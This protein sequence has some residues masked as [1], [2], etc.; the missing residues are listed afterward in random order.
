MR[1]HLAS[2]V[3][4][5]QRHGDQ[6][7][8]VSRHGLR[9]EITSYKTARRPC[10][11]RFAAFLESRGIVKGDRVLIWGENGAPWIAAFFGC[12]LRGVVPVPIDVAG[13]ESFAHRVAQEV[14]P[15]LVT[16]SR[17]Q[18]KSFPESPRVRGFLHVP[19]HHAR[20]DRKTFPNPT[21]SRSS[22][23]P[24]PPADPKGIVHTHANI[25]AS[26]RPI[27]REMQKYLKYERIFHPLRFLHTLPLSHVFG[28]FMGIW[29]PPL[30]AAEV[31][32]ESRLVPSD[33]I[34]TIRDERISVLVAVP[35]VLEILKTYLLQQFDINLE[36][37][38]G[39]SALRRWWMFRKIHR[40]FGFKFW[41]LICGGATLPE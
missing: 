6:I 21:P 28:Q 31:H 35:R 14:D 18:L 9:K 13:S 32:F 25:L 15:K 29:I 37:A 36:K 38:K 16:G 20:R 3:D 12:I 24:E 19:E 22:S 11:A 33:M 26:L 27:E 5:F 40:A 39:H 8:I 17:E 34:E 1:P 41:A 10:P 23:P 7:A 2:L 4:D 30:L